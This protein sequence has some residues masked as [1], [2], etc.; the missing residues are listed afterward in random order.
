MKQPTCDQNKREIHAVKDR[1]F[2]CPGL[3]RMP[4]ANDGGIC[5]IK[6]PL[7]Q[8]QST[9]MVGVAEATT[10]FADGQIELTTRGNLQLRGVQ[11]HDEEK[12]I[13]T[14]LSLGLGPLTPEGDDLRNVMVAPTAGI[15]NSM[16]IDT[17]LIGTKLLEMLQTTKEF[18][19]LSPKFGF[20]INGAETT[21]VVDHIADIWLS[22]NEDGQKFNFGFAS[23]PD[24]S[25]GCANAEGSIDA[26]HAVDFIKSCLECL[27]KIHE[28]FPTVTRMKH[29]RKLPQYSEF[30][31][32]IRDK[33]SY[34]IGKP[35]I[36]FPEAIKKQSLIG[37]FP[38]YQDNLFYIGARPA[39]GRLTAEQMRK[40]ATIVDK[41]RADSAIRITHH[42]GIIVPDCEENE[43][44]TILNDLMEIG[45]ATNQHDAAANV[46]CCAGAPYCHSG[47][48]N[49]QKDGQY[50]IDYFNN[51]T[52]SPIHLTACAK[53][54]VA[55]VPFPYTAVATDEGCY[56]L[57]QSD[58]AS[59]SKFGK[60]LRENLSIIEV[61]NYLDRKISRI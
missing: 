7:G 1:R 59:D 15:D 26:T 2:A 18:F 10:Q 33:F 37:S 9:Q 22:S 60:L 21:T 61:A 52:I 24:Y 58:N 32:A 19:V 30:L 13:D 43:I 36:C 3:F 49:V 46:F 45:Y 47:L 56:N 17:T 25:T 41:R 34:N 40:T 51:K 57:F 39:L 50:L 31:Q 4:K 42:Q 27:V 6:L 12:L 54:C 48:S 16:A 28:Q 20:L 44:P 55:T 38:Q 11:K 8:L 53:A 5:R 35:V 23:R 29:L 14:L